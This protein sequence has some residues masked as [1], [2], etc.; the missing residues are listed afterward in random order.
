MKKTLLIAL[1]LIPFLGICQTTKPIEGFLGIKFGSSKAE[2][3]AAV[4]AKG[5]TLDPAGK[6]PNYIQFSNVN[7]GHRPSYYFFVYFDDDKAY[8]AGFIFKSE[9]EARSVDYYNALVKDIND[10]YGTGKSYKNFKEPYT[11]G[12]GYE[13][14]AISLGKANF[15]TTWLSGDNKIDVFIN[16]KLSTVLNYYDGKLNEA[17]EQKKKAKEKSDF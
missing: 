14:L 4:K 10:V 8:R 9:L 17:A 13:T 16:S 7:L 5:G 12:D 15:S 6:D 2:V 1:M 3:I 11:D